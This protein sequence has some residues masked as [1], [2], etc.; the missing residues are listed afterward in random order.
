MHLA[1][2]QRVGLPRGFGY[3]QYATPEDADEACKSL[4]HGKIDGNVIQVTFSYD[5]LPEVGGS[6]GRR[7][8]EIEGGGGGYAKPSP[9]PDEPPSFERRGEGGYGGGRGSRGRSRSRERR[10][11]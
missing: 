7:E 1:V 6:R 3:V 4:H 11:R 10:G 8:G 9:Y 2:D 5:T